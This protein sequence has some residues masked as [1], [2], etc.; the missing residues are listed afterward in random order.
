MN[1]VTRREMVKKVAEEA[2]ITNKAA[3]TTINL[4]FDILRDTVAQ[5]KAFVIPGVGTI[6]GYL[7]PEKLGRDPRNGNTIVYKEKL[8]ARM[9]S[10]F[11]KKEGE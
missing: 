6:K 9:K 10:Y 5:Q 8:Q 3:N 2:G 11:R 7:R 1:I 4:I